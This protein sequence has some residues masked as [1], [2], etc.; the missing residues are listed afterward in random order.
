[1]S[2]M[3]VWVSAVVLLALAAPVFGAEKEKKTPHI[4]KLSA[5]VYLAAEFDAAATYH[6]LRNCGNGC[7]EANPLL[8]PVARNPGIFVALG[9]SAYGVNYLAGKLKQTGHPRWA[10]VLKI[11]AVGTHTAAAVHTL[12]IK[13]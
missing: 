13:Q 9:V 7:Y 10:K 8:R 3:R 5:A 1:M 12:G 6:Q 4:D 2:K 11:V